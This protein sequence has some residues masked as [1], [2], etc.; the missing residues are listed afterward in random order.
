[1]N[2]VLEYFNLRSNSIGDEGARA[3]A[4]CFQLNTTLLQLLLDG[5]EI[6]VEGLALLKIV[7]K[8]TK[9]VITTTK[10]ISRLL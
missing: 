2:K 5:N 7:S 8:Q 9:C 3:F 4:E 10:Q 6:G 1:V